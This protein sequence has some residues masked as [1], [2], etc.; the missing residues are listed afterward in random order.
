MERFWRKV[1]KTETCWNWLGA[2]NDAGY[3]RIGYNAKVGYAHRFAYELLVG[4]IPEG[5]T[6]DHLC[7]NRRCVNPDH[8]EPV[9]QGDNVRRRPFKTECKHGHAYDEKNTYVLTNG[10]PACRK[11]RVIQVRNWRQ[12]QKVVSDLIQLTDVSQSL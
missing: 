5:L 2:L 6:I 7:R 1:E 3:G 10:R 11:C 9:T 4:P 8:L 12:R